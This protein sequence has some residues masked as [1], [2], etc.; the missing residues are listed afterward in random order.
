MKQELTAP[1]YSFLKLLT[2]C[3]S[4]KRHGLYGFYN[5]I[6]ATGNTYDFLLN[7]LRQ[8]GYIE[9]KGQKIEILDLVEKR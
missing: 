2:L 9:I 1:E 4:P 5:G 8:K 3:L 6:D 7:K